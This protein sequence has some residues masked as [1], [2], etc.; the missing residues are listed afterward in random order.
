VI[1]GRPIKRGWRGLDLSSIETVRNAAHRIRDRRRISN[2]ARSILGRQIS[3]RR[4]P[5][6]WPNRCRALNCGRRSINERPRLFPPNPSPTTAAPRVA[7]GGA[8]AGAA[9]SRHPRPH[10]PIRSPLRDTGMTMNMIEQSYQR[11]FVAQ[12][13]GLRQAAESDSG[14]QFPESQGCSAQIDDTTGSALSRRSFPMPRPKHQSAQ[15]S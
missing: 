12:G 10:S 11:K 7:H 13:T 9:H 3:I 5:A 1:P 2:V 8:M 14:E 6:P 4:S 15:S